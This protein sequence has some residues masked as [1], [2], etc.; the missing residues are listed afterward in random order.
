V[1][2]PDDVVIPVLVL[3]ALGVAATPHHVVARRVGTAA[4]PHDVVKVTD[5]IVG[6]G[7]AVGVAALAAPDDVV[8]FV[9]LPRAPH[10]AQA[11]GVRAR[12]QLA[13]LDH[14]VAPEDVLAPHLLN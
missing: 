6:G 14:V 3:V 8:A 5:Q 12:L 1:A 2:A 10:D 13:A 7:A 11:I 9:G 4:A